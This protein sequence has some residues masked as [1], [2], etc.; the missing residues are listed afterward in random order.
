MSKIDSYHAMVVSKYFSS[1]GDFVKLQ[2]V[3][4][5]Y[6]STLDKFRYNP[7]PLTQTNVKHFPHLETL[8]IYNTFDY[9]YSQ[10]VSQNYHLN[11]Y[12]VVFLCPVSYNFYMQ[13][14]ETKNFV[15]KNVLYTKDDKK[16]FGNTI[17]KIVN[18]FEKDVFQYDTTLIII[19]IPQQ[20]TLLRENSFFYCTNLTSVVLSNVKKIETSCF[21]HCLFSSIVL[22]STLEHLGDKA[23]NYCY[24]LSEITIPGSVTFIGSSCFWGCNLRTLVVEKGVKYLSERSAFSGCESLKEIEIPEGIQELP[25]KCFCDCSHLSRVKL[26]DNIKRLGDMCFDYC[27]K[28]YEIELPASLTYI[29]DDCFQKQVLFK[30]RT[31]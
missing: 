11:H 30:K 10:I 24:H 31:K 16:H 25:K 2:C 21:D 26:S 9:F 12:R 19:T 4:K 7:I 29:G 1:F 8:M 5:K 13:N 22:P 15:F 3:C 17:P 6:N 23:F 28:L 27:E 18:T 20:I 14:S